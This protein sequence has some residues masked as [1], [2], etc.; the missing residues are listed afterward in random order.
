MRQRVL[1]VGEL[2]KDQPRLTVI[3][4]PREHRAEN[5]IRRHIG[6]FRID[7]QC[8]A[9]LRLD[10]VKAFDNRLLHL[11]K[12]VRQFQ[13]GEYL[14]DHAMLT[15]PDSTADGEDRL[16]D[17]AIQRGGGDIAF[18]IVFDLGLHHARDRFRAIHHVGRRARE[19]YPDHIPTVGILRH[20]FDQ[21]VVARKQ[22]IHDD[23]RRR[24]HRNRRG[25]PVKF[26]H[27]D[28]F[29]KLSGPRANL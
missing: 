19:R 6:H 3:N 24:C 21:V 15:F 26:G 27:G 22:P 14:R 16:T 13:L 8:P 20:Q 11:Q 23:L 2:V 28:A 1:V 10:P 9:N 29:P 17:K 12:H 18:R 5:D 25:R 7:V 4:R